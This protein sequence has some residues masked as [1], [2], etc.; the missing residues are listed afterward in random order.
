MLKLEKKIIKWGRKR[1]KRQGI[2]EY[3]HHRMGRMMMKNS[4]QDTPSHS[5]TLFFYFHS[6]SHPLFL[7]LFRRPILALGHQ[8]HSTLIHKFS[9]ERERDRKGEGRKSVNHKHSAGIVINLGWFHGREGE[10]A[11]QTT[12]RS[13]VRSVQWEHILNSILFLGMGL[14][15]AHIDTQKDG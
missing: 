12:N 1:G 11:F 8:K 10:K 7:P 13:L 3:D 2:L 5:P 6:L 14:S 15:D 9:R 4:C